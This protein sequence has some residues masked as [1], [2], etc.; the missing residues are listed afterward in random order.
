MT[1]GRSDADDAFYLKLVAQNGLD[2]FGNGLHLGAVIAAG[3]LFYNDDIRLV[4]ADDE[5]MLL[6]GEKASRKTSTLATSERS[7]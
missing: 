5:V 3:K 2:A 1:R 4:Y 7:T 6:I